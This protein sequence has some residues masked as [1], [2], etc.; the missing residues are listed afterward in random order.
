MFNNDTEYAVSRLTNSYIRAKDYA[1]GLVRVTK[2]FNNGSTKFNEATIQGENKQLQPIALKEDEFEFAVGKLGYVNYLGRAAWYLTRVPIRRDYK[3]GL[4][5]NQLAIIG[6]G[7]K[8]GSSSPVREGEL[9]SVDFRKGI[10]DCLFNKYPTLDATLDLI[11]ETG[12]PVAFSKHFAINQHFKLLYRGSTVGAVNKN[13][14]L[15]L[16]PKFNFLTEELALEAGDDKL[17]KY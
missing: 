15:G 9:E 12:I 16:A 7:G 3:Q 11:E 6:A 5:H 13:G 4:R 2:I 8:D 17:A 14:L 1:Q 10:T